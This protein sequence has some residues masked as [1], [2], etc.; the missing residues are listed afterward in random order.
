[1]KKGYF[2]GESIHMSYQQL[3]LRDFFPLGEKK[4]THSK[5]FLALFFFFYI[6]SISFFPN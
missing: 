5:P 6:N 2:E 1:M 4:S 3:L